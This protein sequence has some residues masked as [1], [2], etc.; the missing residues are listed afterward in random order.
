MELSYH[1][2][3]LYYASIERMEV[4]WNCLDRKDYALAVYLG[5]LSV[6]CILQAIVLK[7]GGVRDA[8]HSLPIWLA[9][10][11][12]S[13]QDAIKGTARNEWNLVVA[14]WD[15]SLRYV[16]KDGLLGYL[17]QK[18]YTTGIY[19]GPESVLRKNGKAL[20]AAAE[21]VQ[22]KGLAQWVSFTK[23]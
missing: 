21:V 11:P 22:R 5:G 19:G 1:A 2:Q 8:K 3:V 9:R 7:L 12:V 14:L 13:M 23:K 10:C 18:G 6:E 16:S 15:N 20:V 4:A 17:R